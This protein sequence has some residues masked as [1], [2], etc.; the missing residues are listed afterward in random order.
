MRHARYLC[1]IAV[2]LAACTTGTSTITGSSVSPAPTSVSASPSATTTPTPSPADEPLSVPVTDPSNLVAGYGSL[3]VRS[4]SDLWEI[5]PRGTVVSKIHDVFSGKLGAVGLQNLAVGVGSVWTVQSRTVLRID[6]STARVVGR[7]DVPRGCDQIAAGAGE[8]FV[9]CRDSRLFAIDPATNKASLVATVGVSPIGLAYGHG[10]VWWINASEAGN[11]SKIDPSTGAIT[12][13]AAPYAKFV[14]PTQ[15]HVWFVDANGRA[16]S[17]DPTGGRPSRSN[18]KARVAIGATVDH[19]S[20]SINDGDLVAFDAE[21]GDITQRAHVSGKQNYRSVAGIA[22]LG[23]N[24]WLVDPE[25]R[26]VAV[27][28]G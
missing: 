19:G 7:V 14:L 5:S 8:M 24:I 11:V 27:P 13:I 26:I 6:P 1:S 20:V 10:A 9:G 16:F 3:W 22:A 28:S 2:L 21:T 17:I 25:G 23:S 18:R 12:T 4:G 15:D